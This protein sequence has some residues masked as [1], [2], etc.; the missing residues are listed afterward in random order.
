MEGSPTIR[1]K[2]YRNRDCAKNALSTLASVGCATPLKDYAPEPN[3]AAYAIFMIGWP[4]RIVRK[5]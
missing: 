2:P 4:N 5:N 1:T 3:F